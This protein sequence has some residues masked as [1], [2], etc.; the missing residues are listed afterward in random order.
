M[1]Y[2]M[3]THEPCTLLH[4]YTRDNSS[5]EPFLRFFISVEPVFKIHY[6]KKICKYMSTIHF[7]HFTSQIYFLVKYPILNLIQIKD[8]GKQK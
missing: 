8:I 5:F 4:K 6:A 2:L 3:Y 7:S 1:H